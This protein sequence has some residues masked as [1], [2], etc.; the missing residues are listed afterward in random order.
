MT[1]G[2]H[3]PKSRHG[4]Q[5]R[6][7]IRTSEASFVPLNQAFTTWGQGPPEGVSQRVTP[8]CPPGYTSAMPST[9]AMTPEHPAPL[10]FFE[11]FAWPVPTAFAGALGAF[12]F[13]QGDVFFR[14]ASAY[15][16]VSGAEEA[17]NVA[18]Q[19]LRPKRSGRATP[20]DADG[21]RRSLLWEAPVV[22]E[23]VDLARGQSETITT[24]QGRLF[25][26]LWVG[27][28][29]WLDPSTDSPPV[30]LAARDLASRI[31]EARGTF[32]KRW[33]RRSGVAFLFVVDLASDASRS[34][35]ATIEAA[36]APLGRP[37]RVALAPERAR[38][39]DGCT[40]PSRAARRRRA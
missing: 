19:V 31:E 16:A 26:T 8:A 25:M 40:H 6:P 3:F 11:G 36:L 28:E 10:R 12:R 7:G 14:E 5:L 22:L 24:S 13:E 9:R 27:D 1:R 30:P 29:R 23:R 18:L 15:E 4:C 35:A 2:S 34:K 21:D 38:A 20:A 33:R 39:S 32:E 37:T 17:G